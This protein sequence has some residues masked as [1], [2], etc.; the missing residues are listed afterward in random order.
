[1]KNWLL[2]R[3]DNTVENNKTRKSWK[4]LVHQP[5]SYCSKS[6]SGHSGQVLRTKRWSF[7]WQPLWFFILFLLDLRFRISHSFS[8]ASWNQLQKATQ[9]PE[10]ISNLSFF[11]PKELFLFQ[12]WISTL[13]LKVCSI[14][15]T[16]ITLSYKNN[17]ASDIWIKEILYLV[18]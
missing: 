8:L 5:L 13:G 15:L 11:F 7:Y 17:S 3:E 9:S 4:A 1:M 6:Q 16:S 12:I 10:Q 2:R 14:R 18:I